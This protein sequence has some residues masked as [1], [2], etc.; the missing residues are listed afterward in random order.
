MT[1]VLLYAPGNWDL[2]IVSK[3]APED[4]GR[5]ITLRQMVNNQIEHTAAHLDEI[6]QTRK[7]HRR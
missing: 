5:T 6:R 7:L 1:R 2:S 3:F 4:E